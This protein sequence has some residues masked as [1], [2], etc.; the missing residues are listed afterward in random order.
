MSITNGSEYHPQNVRFVIRLRSKVVYQVT[1]PH[2]VLESK[3]TLKDE[4]IRLNSVHVLKRK[5]PALRRIVILDKIM[6]STSL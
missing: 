5:A 1:Q 3:G 6:D 4:T 2:P